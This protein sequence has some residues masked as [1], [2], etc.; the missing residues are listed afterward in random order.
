MSVEKLIEALKEA[1]N[2][3][4]SAECVIPM[5]GDDPVAVGTVSQ[6]ESGKILIDF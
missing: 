1:C 2:G 3:D 4:L 6:L 5:Y